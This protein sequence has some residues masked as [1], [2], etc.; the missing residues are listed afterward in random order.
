MKINESDAFLILA[1]M[2]MPISSKIGSKISSKM[3]RCVNVIADTHP[4]KAAS[5]PRDVRSTLR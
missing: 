1:M 5:R 3:P 4:Q 2:S